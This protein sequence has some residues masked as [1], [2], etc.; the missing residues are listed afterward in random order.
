MLQ[1]PVLAPE[2]TGNKWGTLFS[3]LGKGTLAFVNGTRFGMTC[4]R[5]TYEALPDWARQIIL[6]GGV[7]AASIYAYQRRERI[8]DRIALLRTMCKRKIR[9]IVPTPSSK[10]YME[11]VRKGS[12]ER[13]M[14]SCAAQCTI[15]RIDVAGDFIVIGNALRFDE[16]WLVGPDHVLAEDAVYAKGRQSKVSLKGFERVKLATDLVAIRLKS[17]DWARIGVAVLKLG[18]VE[19]SEF[20]SICGPAGTGTCGSMSLD[21]ERFGWT[22][23][24]GTTMPGY[25][26][27]AYQKGP[28]AV[29]MHVHGGV[30]NAGYAAGYI[31]VLLKIHMKMYDED[32]ESYLREQHRRGT[33]TRFRSSP[34]GGDEVIFEINGRF[35][36]HRERNLA[37]HFGENWE[38]VLRPRG[39]RQY[40]RHYRDEVPEGA[41]LVKAKEEPEESGECK[42]S[43]CLGA[44]NANVVT[45]GCQQQRLLALTQEYRKLS[46]AS[47][48]KFRSSLGIL[49]NQP[50][51]SGLQDKSPAS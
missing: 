43:E 1:A 6:C 8:K 47:R 25:S 50:I 27:A 45:Q 28:M 29:S 34:W 24:E 32:T 18:H 9:T 2:V 33:I 42:C 46:R 26:G 44:S 16:D 5:N 40:S 35:E 15:G 4:A 39:G 14:T 30:V 3:G 21:H 7:S 23:Y 37:A 41:N 11:S 48:T 31:W 19:G 20:V 12:E 38:Q 49:K 13:P 36:F 51:T 17:D 22:V 10:V